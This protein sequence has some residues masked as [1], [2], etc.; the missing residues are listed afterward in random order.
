MTYGTIIYCAELSHVLWDI[1][2]IWSLPTSC[3]QYLQSFLKPLLQANHMGSITATLTS[4]WLINP[5]FTVQS[6]AVV[7]LRTENVT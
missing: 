3:Q 5:G 1:K 4:N 2:Y 7:G 6:M